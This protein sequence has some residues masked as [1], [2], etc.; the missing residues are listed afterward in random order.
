MAD[1]AKSG[2]PSLA[3]LTPPAANQ[4]KAIMAAD[5]AAGDMVYLDSNGKFALAT[6]AADTAPSRSVGMLT[7]AAKSG[8]PGTAYF[9]VQF[10]YG[11]GLTPGARYYVSGATAGALADAASTGGTVPVAIAVDATIVYVLPPTR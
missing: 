4:I 11:S 2:T 6:G 9:G 8:Q 7:K 1:V 10:N 3:T 5:G